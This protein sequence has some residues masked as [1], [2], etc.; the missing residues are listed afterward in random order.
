[1][2]KGAVSTTPPV[3]GLDTTTIP[4]RPVAFR[5][6]LAGMSPN[7]LVVNEAEPAGQALAELA[8]TFNSKQ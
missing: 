6:T 3:L 8:V 4:D 7:E 2:A 1:M 5:L